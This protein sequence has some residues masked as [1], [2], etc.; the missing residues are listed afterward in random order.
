MTRQYV[1]SHFG[2]RYKDV[3][4]IGMKTFYTITPDIMTVDIM[5][6]DKM[7][8]DNITKSGKI[9]DET[10]LD[11][12]II[13]KMPQDQFRVDETIIDRMTVDKMTQEEMPYCPLGSSTG[14]QTKYFAKSFEAKMMLL[15]PHIFI[16]IQQF[17]KYFFLQF[18]NFRKR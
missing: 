3:L 1:Y 2:S 7:P 12:M 17:F 11:K 10:V 4:T 8:L 6:V 18:F 13:D 15:F 16:L 9:I 14:K 5:T